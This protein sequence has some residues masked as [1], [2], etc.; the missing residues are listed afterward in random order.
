MAQQVDASPPRQNCGPSFKTQILNHQ[1][2]QSLF[3]HQCHQSLCNCLR[4]QSTPW[5]TVVIGYVTVFLTKLSSQRAKAKLLPFLL[6]QRL[7]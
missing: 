7:A 5:D 3:N 4:T 6:L 1:S 2:H